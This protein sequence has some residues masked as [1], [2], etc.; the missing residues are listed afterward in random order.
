MQN[1]II[2]TSSVFKKS[3][4]E[5][6]QIEF[7]SVS[8]EIDES[9][10]INETP[11][12]LVN[13]LAI[14]KAKKVATT[15][16]GIIIAS[17]Q[18]ATLA[19][20][21]GIKDEILTKPHTRENAIKQLQISSANEVIFLTGLALLNS[22]TQ[23]LQTHVEEFR[24]VFRKLSDR[25]IT[26]Y[27]DNEDVLNCAGSFRSEGLGIALFEKMKGNDHN[28]LIGLPIIKLIDMLANENISVL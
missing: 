4:L 15:Y 11:R 23:S 16:S 1:L 25:E 10:K 9:R 7:S 18:V 5:S 22:Q 26:N 20:G 13:R 28:S 24:V 19:S 21:D 12:Q 14:E 17:D 27:V 3:V 6:L 2:A 8:A